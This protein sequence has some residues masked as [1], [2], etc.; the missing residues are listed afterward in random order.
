M[1]ALKSTGSYI[2]IDIGTGPQR[3]MFADFRGSR[4]NKANALKAALQALIDFR[5]PIADLPDDDP[6]KTA[7]NAQLAAENG[8]RMFKDGSDLVS[9]SNI[10][11][12]VF[13][14][15]ETYSVMQRVAR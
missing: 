9:R 5:Q 3:L 11:E 7:T 15:G 2:E 6:D 10:I 14:D 1:R 12:D 8:G 4:V 13:W